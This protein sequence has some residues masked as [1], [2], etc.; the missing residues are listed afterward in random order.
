MSRTALLTFALILVPF[1]A[2]ADEPPAI[3]VRA[4]ADG[5]PAVGAKVW[6]YDDTGTTE[7]PAEPKP[8]TTDASG[9]VS[10]P[11]AKGTRQ[12]FARDADGRIGWSWIAAPW[13]DPEAK[14]PVDVVLVATAERAGRVTTA[15]GKS[16]AG[17]VI[18]PSGYY[19]ERSARAGPA[20]LPSSIGLPPWEQKRL[21]VRTDAEGR[22]KLVTPTAGYTVTYEIEA[23]GFGKAR[24]A[25][26]AGADLDMKLAA[27]GSV[28][29]TATGV[30][31]AALKDSTIRLSGREP[32]AGKPGARPARS[33]TGAF[34]ATGKA[35][36][37]GVVPGKYALSVDRDARVPAV[38]EK[39]EPVE[40]ASGQ[41]ATATAKFGPAAKVTGR[42]T[43][44]ATGKGMAGVQVIVNVTDGQS[45]QPRDQLYVE[46]DKDGTFTAH[47]PA[48]WYSFWLQT[49]PDGYATPPPT[50]P[51][52][53]LIEPVKVDAG[54]AHDFP[55]YG[56]L[57]TV[58]F[59][60]KVVTAD[61]KPAPGATIRV[62]NFAY[63]SK[64]GDV[65]ADKDG[66]FAIKNLPPDDAVRPRVRFG[67]AVNV[68]ETF[69]LEKTTGPVT[70]EVSETNAAGFKG[71]V[72][73]A[74]GN[75]IAGA[76]V[77]LR[78]SIQGVGRNSGYGTYGGIETEITD[79]DG[80]YS[81]SGCWPRH[82]CGLHVT[83]EGYTA[84]EAKQITGEAGAVKEF[85]D[86]KLARANLTVR[87]TVVGPDGKPVAGA[88]VFGIDGPTRFSTTSGADGTF[89]L[90][91]FHDGAGFVFARKAGYRLAAVPA[92]PA[93]PDRVTVALAKADDPPPAHQIPAAHKAALDKFTRHAL[94]LVWETHPMFGYGGNVLGDMARIDLDTAKKWRDAEKKRT[95]GK[96]DFTHLIERV[97]RE[98]T[99]FDTARDDT[100]EALAVIGGLKADAGFTDAMR[101]GTQMLAVDKAKALRLA[102]E[103]VVKARQ[104]EFPAKVW[105]LAEAGDLAARAGSAGGKK[106]LAEA[107]EL[108]AKLA[109]DERG[110]NSLAVGL[111]AA[112][113]APYDWPKAEELL[114]TLKDPGDYNRFLSAAAARLAVTD[115]D[116][117][118]KL[119]DRFKPDNT[120]YPQTVRLRVSFA[121]AKDKPD[122]AL[123]LVQSV[124]EAHYRFLGMIQLAVLFAPT[125][126]PRAVKTIDAAFDALEADAEGHRSWGSSGG[127]AGLA[128]V[129]AV[130]AKE[131]GHPDVASLVA[132]TLAL[133]P[134]G[135]D[136]WSPEDRNDQ[137]VNIAAAL[138]LVDPA[139]AR[140]VLAGVAPPDEFVKRA[141]THRRDW[142]FALALADPERAV[143]LADKLVERAKEARG[144]R[145]AISATGLVELG[146]ILTAPDRLRLLTMYGNLPRE[147]G[148]DD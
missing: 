62:W 131:I 123:E 141:L 105:S 75:P 15:D 60:G 10:V 127:R 124:K 135:P 22:F 57:K 80:R 63:P 98:K 109:P 111:V 55:P 129:A 31:P 91:G 107:A 12:L 81:F 103:A 101:V 8:L 85:P 121:I 94:T 86:V 42:V 115:F 34:D 16:V 95:D 140:H 125:D 26:S 79:A 49:A 83:A 65:T 64:D 108:A 7:E 116:R 139:A 118:R 77:R 137:L 18:T 93:K 20:G 114:K 38:F 146:S 74:R 119:F 138:A 76:K 84:G 147:V 88:E 29:V 40:V 61:G 89:T 17:A 3:V 104:R 100:D 92:H 59:T 50:G 113:I 145:N 23:D 32:D 102:E 58:T 2:R 148:D 128:A 69:E 53:G 97:R 9:K 122:A 132:R 30:E 14:A 21:A 143:G 51:R 106:I 28:T 70:L 144:G 133:R 44:R 110:R 99:L 11:R 33:F 43:D 117:A 39:A 45:P 90:T 27:P 67:K 112:R 19:A 25:A 142:L 130:R 66:N 41:A 96:T 87:G 24:W 78:I 6:V 120:F 68:P 82:S 13:D 35:T 48:A 134:T 126:R 36:V 37:K 136:A 4:L 47:G 46:T 73:D 1:A 71:R 52:R 5:K 54:K 56:L 72:T